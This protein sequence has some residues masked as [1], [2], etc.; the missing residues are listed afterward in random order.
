MRVGMFRRGLRQRELTS[1]LVEEER[2]E[3]TSLPTSLP[4]MPLTRPDSGSVALRSIE[5]YRE[6]TKFKT[7]NTT[8]SQLHH[9]SKPRRILSSIDTM[10]R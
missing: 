1:A 10:H 5:L 6:A 9:D 8:N 7:S 4:Q 3:S 2:H